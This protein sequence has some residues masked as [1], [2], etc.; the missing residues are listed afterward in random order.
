M[1]PILVESTQIVARALR[2]VPSEA[3]LREAEAVERRG[4][5]NAN[6]GIPRRVERGVGVGFA[7][8]RVEIAERCA[9]E[10]E[11]RHIR[12]TRA[13]AQL[14]RLHFSAALMS[15]AARTPESAEASV[16]SARTVPAARP[17]TCAAPPGRC[18]DAHASPAPPIGCFARSP[19]RIALCSSIV[20]SVRARS[21]AGGAC[22][23]FAR[24]PIRPLPPRGE[25]RVARKSRRGSAGREHRTLLVAGRDRGGL[26]VRRGARSRSMR[27]VIDVGRNPSHRRDFERLAHERRFHDVA[28]PDAGDVGSF[29]RLHVT[30]RSSA[31]RAKRLGREAG[32][33]PPDARRSRPC[34]FAR[35]A[36]SF[37]EMIADS[38][39]VV[40]AA[41]LRRRHARRAGSGG[42][43]ISSRTLL[44]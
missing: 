38:Q 12:A 32:A 37:S 43:A 7:D 28:H 44:S 29:L 30:S 21:A 6:A 41:R 17:Q 2:Q 13:G 35:R 25:T 1:R 34:R 31:S 8:R 42:V 27:L 23:R 39:L 19:A 24:A 14:S 26:I 36:A 15:Q 22:A 18:R 9:A 33:T 5:E 11:H 4:I 3:L 20:R 16:S 10:A 40:D